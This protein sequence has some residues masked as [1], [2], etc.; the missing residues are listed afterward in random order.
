MAYFSNVDSTRHILEKLDYLSLKSL[1]LTSREMLHL[2][3]DHFTHVAKNAI[4]VLDLP[5]NTNRREIVELIY[6]LN[7]YQSADTSNIIRNGD[8]W[9]KGNNHVIIGVDP[10]DDYY[11]TEVKI[12]WMLNGM[13]HRYDGPAQTVYSEEGNVIHESWYQK[14]DCHRDDD[15]PAVISYHHFSGQVERKEWFRM[16]NCHRDTGPAIIEYYENGKLAL[17]EWYHEGYLHRDD[18][19]ASVF[20]RDDGVASESWYTNGIKQRIGGPAQIEY[21]NGLI[22]SEEWFYEGKLHRDDGPAK[23]SYHKN[24]NKKQE[25]WSQWHVLHRDGAPAEINYY[26]NGKVYG[27][28]WYN[29]GIIYKQVWYCKDGSIL[30]E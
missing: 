10:D 4:S 18:G 19:P 14:G 3:K 13:L 9:S 27:E 11:E 20:Y 17:E 23:T 5:Q 25:Q 6:H 1:A 2:V 26:K 30:G 15:Q 12:R 21:S 29:Q 28:L 22:E 8:S 24:G 7:S 16:S